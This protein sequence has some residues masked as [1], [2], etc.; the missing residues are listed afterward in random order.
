MVNGAEPQPLKLWGVD[1]NIDE[2]LVPD[3]TLPD[4]LIKP[5]GTRISDAA[6]WEA[7]RPQLVD[8]MARDMYGLLPEVLRK[9][10]N[11]PKFVTFSVQEESSEAFSGKAIRRQ[12]AVEF[13][14]P[15]TNQIRQS[16]SLLLYIPQNATKPRPAFVGLNFKGNH[17]VCDD[18][19]ILIPEYADKRS[20]PARGAGAERWPIERILDAGF[21]VATMYYGQIVFDRDIT[22]DSY[23]PPIEGLFS[24]YSPYNEKSPRPA[25]GWGFISAWAYGLS[26]I[27]DY[28][29]T[30]ADI[31]ATRVA[32]VGHS[33]LGK[34]ALWAG[35]MDTRFALIISNDSGCGGAAL[36]YREF[37]ERVLLHNTVRP[38]WFCLNW[39]QYGN[40]VETMP[41]DS[42]TLLALLAPRPVYVASATKD[43][44]ADPR[45]EFLAL[46][47]AQGVY[48]LY[49]LK[50]LVD[51]AI[52]LTSKADSQIA[53]PVPNQSVGVH[54][55]YH[56]REGKHDITS[57]DW[58]QYLKFAQEYL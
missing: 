47:H 1:S 26:R 5:D 52:P 28:L 40:A 18:P 24:I 36:N 45:G 54:Q 56:I 6:Q 33:R 34:T 27:L 50:G 11:H 7:Y 22:P 2:S 57:F 38:Y 9:S 8:L 32:V 25:D 30:D 31:D 20:A 53:L 16:A 23:G 35:A 4:P 37:G 19:A 14:D 44:F 29:E 41:F 46:V 42:H 10:G 12:V 39:K 17:T 21:A 55:R 49:G 51:S 48:D 13:R 58:E 43:P 3:Y 15:E